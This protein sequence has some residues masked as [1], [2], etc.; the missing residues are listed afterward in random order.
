MVLCN[1]E[2]VE[3]VAQYLD[4]LPEKLEF[5]DKNVLFALK[6][7]KKSPLL[8]G[9]N[10]IIQML[11]TNSK[12]TD[13]FGKDKESQ[14]RSQQ[15]LEYITVCVNHMDFPLNAKRI[16]NELN[17]ALIGVTY[18]AGIEKTIADITLYYILHSIMKKL[19]HQDKAQYVHVSRWFD[20]VQQEEKLRRELDLISFDLMHIFL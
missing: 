14:A 10:T 19:S 12:C 11:A 5:S 16:L 4:I 13:I 20:N 15:W 1:S 18:L 7:E 2:C 9:F 8:Q 17:T 6:N 3:K